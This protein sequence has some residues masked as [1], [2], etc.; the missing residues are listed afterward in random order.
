MEEISFYGRMKNAADNSNKVQR[1]IHILLAAM[2]ALII[3]ALGVLGVPLRLDKLGAARLALLA[4]IPFIALFVFY[5]EVSLPS[6]SVFR[7]T[8]LAY[9]IIMPFM[10]VFLVPAVFDQNKKSIYTDSFYSKFLPGWAALWLLGPAAIYILLKVFLYIGRKIAEKETETGSI[11]RDTAVMFTPQK[12][13]DAQK[14]KGKGKKALAIFCIVIVAL[15][16]FLFAIA[17]FLKNVYGNMEFEAIWFTIRYAKG[18]LAVEDIIQGTEYTLIFLAIAGYICLKPV[19]CILYDK[20]TVRDTCAGGRYT[21]SMTGKKRA[22]H[23]VLS[24]LMLAACCAFFCIQTNFA[25]YMKQK[26]GKSYIYET[27]YVKPDDSVITFPENKRN[28]IFIF[29]ESM[30]NTYAS[31]EAGGSQDMNYISELTELAA[32]KDSVN[33]SNTG[34]LGGASVFVPAITNTQGS[35]VAQT[36]GISLITK[37]FPI[38]AAEDYPSFRR[39]EDVMHDNGYRQIYIEGSK[40]EFSMYDQYVARYE[41]STL[42]DRVAIVDKGYASEDGDY[43]W[44]WGI[45]DRKLFDVT[46]KLVTEA[47]SGD[48]P[49]FVTMYTMDTHSF[50]SGH[51]C[52]LCDESIDNAYLASVDCAS[53]QVAEFVSWVQD[54]PFY[55]N[56]TIV[57][58]GDHLGNEKAVGAYIADG[59]VRTTYNCFINPAKEPVNTGSRIFSSLDMFPTTISAIGAQ[60][61]GDRLGLGTDLFSGTET[62]CEKLGEEEYKKQL[63]QS[64]DYYD[65]EF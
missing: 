4:G 42:Y 5:M 48:K 64:S 29:I 7:S 6:P 50:E 58:V 23:A 20:V 39:L 22:M 19:K 28:L 2:G 45:E 65:S 11:L 40:G 26:L 10:Q 49:F 33:F 14:S 47:A 21:L 31:K 15:A 16:S 52:V 18:G 25:E 63:Q 57:L 32:A 53:R 38:G 46:K 12:K 59:Y 43:I 41:D 62:L 56:T 8:H 30:E 36:T 61:K 34:L 3:T 13:L 27:Y 51:R 9:I 54:Q 55:G 1:G 17:L 44:K 37:L 35:T 24:L 60:I